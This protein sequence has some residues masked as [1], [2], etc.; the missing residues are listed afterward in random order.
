MRFSPQF[1]MDYDEKKEEG[2]NLGEKIKFSANEF[3][4]TISKDSLKIT[5]QAI[6]PN[7]FPSMEVILDRCVKEK[8]DLV[9]LPVTKHSAIYLE[10]NLILNQE[11]TNN[12]MKDLLSLSSQYKKGRSER[13]IY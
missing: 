9:L 4:V 11:E 2:I 12:Y 10:D 5:F 3:K 6:D 13:V 8:P 1:K 7:E